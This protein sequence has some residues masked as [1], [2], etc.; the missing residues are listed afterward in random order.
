MGSVG[1]LKSL[2]GEY[3]NKRLVIISWHSERPEKADFRGSEID[4]WPKIPRN[5]GPGV[6]YS[7]HS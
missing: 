3:R 5:I 7:W 4:S 6:G 1:L 2:G